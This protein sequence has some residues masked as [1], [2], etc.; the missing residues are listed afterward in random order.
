MNKK[1][2]GYFRL[3]EAFEKNG[4]PVCRCMEEDAEKQIR[5]FLHEN[6]H[7][8]GLRSK[9]RESIGPCSWHVSFLKGILDSTPGISILYADILD[10]LTEKLRNL[11]GSV[12]NP[13]AWFRFLR[14]KGLY[15]KPCLFCRESFLLENRYLKTLL[16][17]IENPEF[18]RAY[19]K[20][21]GICV[22]HLK[23]LLQSH[24]NESSI[25]WMVRFMIS[26]T[27]ILK[28]E[29]ESFQGKNDWKNEKPCTTEEVNALTAVLKFT[30]GSPGIFSNQIR[31]FIPSAEKKEE[32]MPS[33][34]FPAQTFAAVKEPAPLE[35]QNKK[36][37]LQ[38]K[39]LLQQLNEK[40]SE[41]A[42][43]KFK[44]FEALE[45]KKTLELQLSGQKAET[46]MSQ[47][48]IENLRDEIKKLQ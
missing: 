39:E 25:K 45:V 10:G 23:F 43:L 31:S 15:H 19:S 16:N 36:L 2:F 22:P 30:T 34:Q 26:K 42:S 46:E 21:D 44:L 5:N 12:S 3:M 8:P 32:D 48:A 35:V 27:E 24:K 37:E 1:Y 38:T 7:D 33:E 4:C 14:K 13:S 11:R 29:L 28:K 47:K 41:L 17:F 9:L 18:Q 6:I 40:S 20:S